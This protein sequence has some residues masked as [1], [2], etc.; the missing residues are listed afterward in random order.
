MPKKVALVLSGGGAKGAF[1]CGAEKYA[2]EV[3]GYNW[4]LIAGVSVGALNGAMLAMK[5][6]DRLFEL[7]NTIS[8]DQV[9][10]GGFN[11][12]STLKILF[13]A[14][15]FYGNEPLKRMLLQ[16]LELDKIQTDLRI[17]AVSLLSG[18]YVEFRG[19]DPNL[20]QAI[21]A[22]TVMPIIWTPVDVSAQHKSMVDGGVR[23]ISPIG[24]VLDAEPDEVV[25]INC[26]PQ[27]ADPLP[28]PPENIVKIGLRTLDIMLNELFTSDVREFVR[29][30][31]LVKQ[32]EKHGV[33][34]HHPTS[35]RP[36]KY[37]DYKLIEP[38]HPLGDTLDFSQPVVQKSLR[39]GTERARQVL[40][41]VKR[42][43]AGA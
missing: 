17:G 14:K 28:E 33:T 16:E 40:E 6:Y 32:V 34:L 18:E 15:S 22:S 31:H 7:W 1:Q 42:W 20:A 38:L 19:D 10:T 39:A 9:Y 3:K 30:N 11:V 36:L 25:I 5:K 12:I 43:G 35:G 13:G 41:G 24:D 27:A 23:N 37:Y 21:L 29:I 4:D 26:S 8:N 2:R